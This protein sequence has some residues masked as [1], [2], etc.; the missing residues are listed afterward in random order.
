MCWSSV[1]LLPSY[2][3]A[4]A[5]LY[6]SH[7]TLQGLLKHDGKEQYGE[8]FKM[9]QKQPAEFE[10]DGRLP[11]RLAKYVCALQ[12]PHAGNALPVLLP[13]LLLLRGLGPL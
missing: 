10:L 7:T 9:W 8:Q 6:N 13:V 4:S 3:T 11:V 5:E 12:H 1:Q 2:T